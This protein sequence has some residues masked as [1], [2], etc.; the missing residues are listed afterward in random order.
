[1]KTRDVFKDIEEKQQEELD[2][3][4]ESART[5]ASDQFAE[6]SKEYGE[7]VSQRNDYVEQAS[8]AASEIKEEDK[9][10][11][12]S[13]KDNF[14]QEER[15]KQQQ[16]AM[17]N[18]SHE[19]KMEESF[20]TK[21]E[22]LDPYAGSLSL[23][24]VEAKRR[25]LESIAAQ[26]KEDEDFLRNQYLDEVDEDIRMDEYD[27]AITGPSAEELQRDAERAK[28]DQEALD[29]EERTRIDS[30]AREIQEQKKKARKR[31]AAKTKSFWRH[32]MIPEYLLKEEGTNLQKQSF[33]DYTVINPITKIKAG[34]IGKELHRSVLI[35]DDWNARPEPEEDIIMSEVIQGS[36][37]DIEYS[38]LYKDPKDSREIT[39]V[40]RI[41]NTIETMFSIHQERLDRDKKDSTLAIED[42][43]VDFSNHFKKLSSAA[44]EVSELVRKNIVSPDKTP[45]AFG[46]LLGETS[47]DHPYKFQLTIIEKKPPNK[48]NTFV[49]VVVH[50]YSKEPTRDAIRALFIPAEQFDKESAWRNPRVLGYIK[51]LEL[52]K[53]LSAT[54]EE[55]KN[56]IACG[57]TDGNLYAAIGGKVDS[58]VLDYVAFS[59]EFHTGS[60]HMSRSLDPEFAEKTITEKLSDSI[61]A[62]DQA[63]RDF[64]DQLERDL[65]TER[66]KLKGE[67][68]AA[69]AQAQDQMS[70]YTD[71]SLDDLKD[72]VKFEMPQF[73][74][75]EITKIFKK[76]YF[77]PIFLKICPANI[78]KNISDCL[79]PADCREAITYI[80]L[81]KAR[82]YMEIL[83]ATPG[84]SSFADTSSL[85][86][87]LDEWDKLVESNY[88]FK[89]VRFEGEAAL[90]NDALLS[91]K[92]YSNDDIS[93]SFHIN[94]SGEEFAKNRKKTSYIMNLDN[95][96]SVMKTDAEN[97]RIRL[98]SE[99]G[100]T[101]DYTSAPLKTG[102]RFDIFDGQTHQV[103]FSYV[104]A[105]G[106][107]EFYVD[108]RRVML[109][110][111]SGNYFTGRLGAKQSNSFSIAS[112]TSNKVEKPFAGVLD[113][114]A[115]WNEALD[116]EAWAKV[117]KIDSGENYRTI[118]IPQMTAWWR[119]GDSFDDYYNKRDVESKIVDLVHG[120]DLEFFGPLSSAS[121]VVL[122]L[123]EPM[124]E[125]TFLNIIDTNLNISDLCRAIKDLLAGNV[126]TNF[127]LA[128]LKKRYMPTFPTWSRNANQE[129]V[130]ALQKS[131]VETL[132]KTVAQ[133]LFTIVDKYIASCD[134]WKPLAKALAKGTFN[135]SGTPFED[136][137]E[138]SPIFRLLDDVGKGDYTRLVSD[139]L[140]ILTSAAV[141]FMQEPVTISSNMSSGAGET[142]VKSSLGIGNV[143]LSNGQP[144]GSERNSAGLNALGILNQGAGEFSI[145]GENTL[146]PRIQILN[147]ATKSMTADELLMAL[148]GNP[149]EN[150]FSS[151]DSIIRENFADD[152]V[153]NDL[154]RETVSSFYSSMG[155]SLG[156]SRSIDTLT[157]LA[158]EMNKIISP[159]DDPCEPGTDFRNTIGQP[160]TPT[161]GRAIKDF[162]KNLQ[163]D[164]EDAGKDKSCDIK[165]PMSVTERNSL[166]QVISDAYFP[167]LDAYDK[168]M[169]L[170]KMGSV[171]FGRK[172]RKVPK[173]L[174]KGDNIA[175]TVYEN[176]EIVTKRFNIEKT[177]INPEFEA[178]LEQGY[179]PLKEDS[180]ECGTKFGGVVKINWNILDLFKEEGGF[181]S[182]LKP[183]MSLAPKV[184][185]DKV[186]ESDVEI[187]DIAAAL[188]PYTDY[189]DQPNASVFD[190]VI[191][192]GGAAAKAFSP[193]SFDFIDGPSET[194]T[195]YFNTRDTG[196]RRGINKILT[197]FK[198]G[199]LEANTYTN[200]PSITGVQEID[201]LSR[202]E[203]YTPFQRS[204][205]GNKSV[206]FTKSQPSPMELNIAAS[207][208]MEPIL[209]QE[210]LS[211]GYMEEPEDCV[212][213]PSDAQVPE[214][215]SANVY[216]PQ[217]NVFEFIAQRNNTELPGSHELK[218]DAYNELYKEVLKA[219]S[220]KV[221]ESPLLKPV[222]GTATNN[223][224]G[225]LLGINFLNLTPSPRLIDMVSF[226]DQVAED[227]QRLISCPE[228]LEEPPLT[229]ALKTSAPRILARVCVLDLMLKGVI[230]FSS[231][232]LSKKDGVIKQFILKRMENDLNTFAPN[233]SHHM[234]RIVEQYNILATSGIIPY[235]SIEEDM[236]VIMSG[237]W[238]TAM[239][240]F[241]EEEFDHIAGKL[242]NL[243]HGGCLPSGEEELKSRMSAIIVDYA[244]KGE[245]NIKIKQQVVYKDGRTQDDIS[246]CDFK[247]D[248]EELD[249]ITYEIYFS[250]EDQVITLAKTEE[251]VEDLMAAL[252]IDLNEPTPCE[253]GD[254]YPDSGLTTETSGHQ[255]EYD[256]DS[257]G[258][259][260]TSMVNGHVH[261]IV[262]YAVL[263]FHNSAGEVLHNHELVSIP[264]SARSNTAVGN[265]IKEYLADKLTKTMDFRVLF[266][267][268]FSLSDAAGLIVVYGVLSAENQIIESSFKATKKAVFDLFDTLW[269][270]SVSPDPCKTA[271][272]KPNMDMS[273]LFPGF[274]DAMFDPALLISMLLAPL[275]T[276]RGWTKVTDPNVFITTTITDIMKL[277]IIPNME[278]K[279][280]PNPFNNMEIECMEVPTWNPGT[281]P[282]DALFLNTFGVLSQPVIE[283]GIATG[284]GFGVPLPPG[285]FGLI[286]YTAVGPLIFILKDLPRL[287]EKLGDNEQAKALVAATG[288]NVSANIPESCDDVA[289][290]TSETELGREPEEVCPPI[291]SYEEIKIDSR[292]DKEC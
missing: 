118:N 265:R 271:I 35:S 276:Y 136:M 268:S 111:A 164:V 87:A 224:A 8:S 141:T 124:D 236:S 216:T 262:N 117:G 232:F 158:Q 115:F 129:M 172:E 167:V 102:D 128:N 185:G 20:S 174:W 72:S 10:W 17:D 292:S 160:I 32:Q 13:T 244:T 190:P 170:F 291:R 179:I 9:S 60:P 246:Q 238:K 205:S 162:F 96:F 53:A 284:L 209:R 213:T 202:I 180:T 15:E 275:L 11:W 29:A 178:L 125:D 270:I 143:A 249:K 153:A 192:P 51:K 166:F 73:E 12:E 196:S 14:Q 88:N 22:P 191:E 280:I 193:E 116:T 61:D 212:A 140:S 261:A 242:H 121:V 103:G 199:L 142:S 98:T 55:D 175:R 105:S 18:L 106:I 75:G 289:G 237:G 38:K 197:K 33:F 92:I 110:K 123:V 65:A 266:D 113:E 211:A 203:H 281:S 46:T 25:E 108:G 198:S 148:G 278:F 264:L 89:A 139:D 260:V 99:S 258:N 168:D 80:G 215:G 83:L 138:T 59:K 81:W 188:G 54:S 159:P 290:A 45:A 253:V 120:Q 93:V 43:S 288:L 223:G 78:V 254:T 231:L 133:F 184:E 250:Y 208:T 82:E 67:W 95:M 274:G 52:L 251:S 26:E 177:Q 226:S 173:V 114:V 71:F 176:D 157:W 147:L 218:T 44:S 56:K 77:D 144:F 161:E 154:D 241:I 220:L 171:S 62:T 48:S 214:D 285:P 130:I 101:I 149:D 58:R 69:K 3:I 182:E 235:D 222:Q 283:G 243:V 134:N 181:L 28:A 100:E 2:K 247:E 50:F 204:L 16:E 36:R 132:L 227:F 200:Q 272:S 225:P 210:L 152:S 259:G 252:G 165:L 24:D 74:D 49:G 217:E 201:S 90:R 39:S 189:D 194:G 187:K 1:M 127:D 156:V 273:R 41:P 119:M 68:D 47:T 219:L 70:L 263:P 34:S 207:F 186:I 23:S 279:N 245:G 94:T 267:F 146:D 206:K 37:D 239:S 195:H 248:V 286:Y 169:I 221:S 287:I 84:L 131:A 104:A 183:P 234:F 155:K 76:Y 97:L 255:H 107:A 64:N 228:G 257:S 7:S 42:H 135:L 40:L 256:I 112:S 150:L 233:P 86:A 240:Y 85:E 79:L 66:K 229:T 126:D 122:R 27:A 6:A 151:I 30:R 5:T 145:T 4:N 91:E 21:K 109:E 137:K 230:P 31:K 19:N 57:A 163:D 269:T 63:L 282:L 277:P